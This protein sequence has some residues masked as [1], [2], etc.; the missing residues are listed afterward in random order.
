MVALLVVAAVDATAMA[1]IGD[2]VAHPDAQPVDDAAPT[3]E[4]VPAGRWIS[5]DGPSFPRS[6]VP[7]LDVADDGSWS[8]D[9]DRCFDASGQLT[10]DG[11]AV[12]LSDVEVAPL[13]GNCEL[14]MSTRDLASDLTNGEG[15][16]A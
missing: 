8:L 13:A 7:S 4:S 16:Y 11:T 15:T 9:Q 5:T 10:V 12:T 14:A 2:Q 6:A 3:T 1:A